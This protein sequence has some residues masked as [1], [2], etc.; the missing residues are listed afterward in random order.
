[1]RKPHSAGTIFKVEREESCKRL[2]KGRTSQPVGPLAC[3]R[4]A[5]LRLEW[6]EEER[7]VAD[8]VRGSREHVLVS[9]ETIVRILFYMLRGIRWHWRAE[10]E[11]I[12]DFCFS[13]I[14]GCCE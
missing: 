13:N 11:E 9:L 12:A 14:T 2:A 6:S 8:V 4:R 10:P 7:T 3:W 1:M 5:Q